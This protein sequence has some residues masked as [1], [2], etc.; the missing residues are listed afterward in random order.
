MTSAEAKQGASER[1]EQFARNMAGAVEAMAGQS[2][3]GEAK[4]ANQSALAQIGAPLVIRCSF[5]VSEA[6]LTIVAD[7]SAWAAISDAALA[8]AGIEDSDEEL[9]KQTW[10]ELLTQAASP[11]LADRAGD[12]AAGVSLEEAGSVP[13]ALGELFILEVDLAGNRLPAFLMGIPAELVEALAPP[14]VALPDPQPRGN[15][16][17]PATLDRLLDVELP[18][19]ISFGKTQLPVQDILKLSTGSII[20][21]NCPANEFVEIIVNNC[22]IARGEVVVIEGNY[23]VR[24]KEIISRGERMAL[25]PNSASPVRLSA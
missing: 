10:Q 6:K 5:G 25:H 7:Q 22:T 18:L 12:P 8:G 20:E 13:N 2:A 11:L 9:K 4:H 15:M 19:S 23:G 21:L 1:A 24:I 14:Q 17:V 16:A 3:T